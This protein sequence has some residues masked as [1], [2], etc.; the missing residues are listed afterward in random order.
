MREH[1]IV[2]KTKNI[3]NNVVIMKK[4]LIY[5][6]IL[7]SLFAIFV[8][9][10][11]V[12]NEKKY[13]SVNIDVGKESDR[14]KI[15][16]EVSEKTDEHV[17]V[18]VTGL[19]ITGKI[20]DPK[21]REY[22]LHFTENTSL[23]A[24]PV[25]IQN[26]KEVLKNINN[27]FRYSTDFSK[28]ETPGTYIVIVNVKDIQEEALFYIDRPSEILL[29]ILDMKISKFSSQERETIRNVEQNLE[30]ISSLFGKEGELD[31]SEITGIVNLTLK[32]GTNDGALPY[33]VVIESI[34]ITPEN[35]IIDFSKGYSYNTIK[36]NNG[37]VHFS[38]PVFS[39]GKYNL[40]LKAKGAYIYEIYYKN[41]EPISISFDYE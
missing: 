39:H 23:P 18:P 6:F 4:I 2:Y 38:H 41:S 31:L 24:H 13:L 19:N 36:N 17:I 1:G 14:V 15:W 26:P 5:G 11:S 40:T 3:S 28:T 10:L 32:L 25:N 12:K 30:M 29:E 7:I 20:I 34:M 22:M 8:F 27:L 9:I 37:I 21:N 35:H 16:V 33:E